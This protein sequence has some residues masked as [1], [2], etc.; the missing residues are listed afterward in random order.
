MAGRPAA[1]VTAPS[2]ELRTSRRHRRAAPR[3]ATALPPAANQRWGRH[4]VEVA[5]VALTAVAGGAA[6]LLSAV[7]KRSGRRR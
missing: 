3:A 1:S 5:A 7:R 6:R 2:H 4:E